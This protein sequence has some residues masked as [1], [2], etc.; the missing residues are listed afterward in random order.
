MNINLPCDHERLAI[1]LPDA[2]LHRITL[3]ERAP[4]APLNDPAAALAQ[5]L[6]N[7][8]GCAPLGELA[9][10]RRSVCIVISDITRPVPNQLLLPP[11]LKT[12][13]E[14]GVARESISI[15]IAT[16]MHR[17]N[18][19]EELLALVGADIAARYTVLNHDCH[20]PKELRQVAVIDGWPIEV[21]R[22]YL[23]AD[24]KILTG[25]IE[26]HPFA[27]YSGGGKSILPGISS[28]ATMKFMHSYA[29]VD[30]PQVGIGRLEDNPFRHY[31]DQ[32][33]RAAGADFILNVVLDA[34]RR[35]TGVFAGEVRQA[36][37]LGC[38]FAEQ[39]AI[40]RL[41]RQAD[42]LVTTGGGAPLDNT[43]Y[44]AIKGM[45][46]ARNMVH[47]GGTIVL[48]AGCREGLGSRHYCDLIQSVASP[49]AFR[50][51]YSDP[52]NF[53]IDQWGAQKY[54]QS[55]EH[56]DTV[57]LYSPHLTQ[58]QIAPFGMTRLDDLHAGLERLFATHRSAYVVPEGP[59][60]GCV[61]E[62]EKKERL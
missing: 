15:L 58:E 23:E 40:L 4:V 41:E 32:V 53:V 42:L 27:G 38:S 10:N 47:P 45:G 59:Y 57:Y 11:L 3:L 44:Q 43:L 61:Y 54:F 37:R 33:S 18:L 30:H 29:L 16:G 49:Q 21:N 36:H 1:H 35:I 60:I 48:V 7:P 20:D 5:A 28:F 22:H 34:E 39:H 17:P 31:V 2:A 13:E 62:P 46:A 14:A 55:I 12:I 25:L 8:C 52:E 9:K 56:V 26:P 19:G 24:L 6:R 51:R 50:Q